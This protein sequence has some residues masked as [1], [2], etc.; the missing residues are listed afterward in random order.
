[1]KKGF[2][3]VELVAVIT[4]LGIVFLLIAPVVTNSLNEAKIKKMKSSADGYI[5]AAAL[6]QTNTE[7]ELFTIVDGVLKNEE[8]EKIDTSAGEKDNGSVYM[9]KS[10]RSA[11]VLIDEKEK[12]CAKKDPKDGEIKIS[13]YSASCVINYDVDC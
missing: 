2:T 3:L 8:N 6:N 4:I 7:G 12:Y 10:G 9:C 1:M 5:R 11:I 13:D